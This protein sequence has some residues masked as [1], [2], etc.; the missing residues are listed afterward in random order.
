MNPQEELLRIREGLL[1]FNRGKYLNYDDTK[2]DGEMILQRQQNN[3]SF[4]RPVQGDLI[5]VDGEVKRL[6]HVYQSE[7]GICD[8]QI[9]DNKNSGY[10]LNESGRYSYSGSLRT[11]QQMRLRDS[12]KT[13]LVNAWVFQDNFAG[14]GCGVHFKARVRIWEQVK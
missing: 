1:H 10:Y 5:V 11:S 12:G 4:N 3:F 6:G 9:A 13:E 8:F 2:N 7:N 14:A